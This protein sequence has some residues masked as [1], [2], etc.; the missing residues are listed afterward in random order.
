MRE[1]ANPNYCCGCRWWNYRCA[2][3]EQEPCPNTLSTHDLLA[4]A[5]SAREVDA[6]IEETENDIRMK[7][8]NDAL[9]RLHLARD[10]YEAGGD[11][12]ERLEGFAAALTAFEAAD[13]AG[14]MF[15]VRIGDEEYTVLHPVCDGNGIRFTLRDGNGEHKEAKT[16]ESSALA[17]EAVRSITSHLEARGMRLEE[18]LRENSE[19]AR[20][21]A[22][23]EKAEKR[24]KSIKI[25]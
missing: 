9:S 22:L 6:A 1:P 17:D 21:Q 2:A 5:H 10:S 14:V 12:K 11:M 4:T 13:Y 25:Q 16:S 20:R 23:I 3:P 7:K 18:A 19:L 8:Y 15:P 24:N